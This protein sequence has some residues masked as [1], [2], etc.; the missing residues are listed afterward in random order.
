MLA[1][2]AE[3]EAEEYVAALRL[4]PRRVALLVF[5]MLCDLGPVEQISKLNRDTK[6][7]KVV[8]LLFFHFRFFSF[9]S[10]P[11]KELKVPTL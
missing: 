6:F 4:V 2:D 3:A 8:P 5:F 1:E 10:R 7:Q 11:S 9:Y